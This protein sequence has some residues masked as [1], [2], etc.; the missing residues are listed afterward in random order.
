MNHLITDITDILGCDYEKYPIAQELQREGLTSIRDA[1]R[2]AIDLPP[3]SL[4]TLY[5]ILQKLSGKNGSATTV[6]K[7][8]MRCI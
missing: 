3:G 4:R 5:E 2:G 7:V 6:E 1:G 8:K